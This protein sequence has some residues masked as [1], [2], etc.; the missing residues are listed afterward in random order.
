MP[1]A[2]ATGIAIGQPARFE[3]IA[4][5][6]Q[7]FRG[8]VA[9]VQPVVD[10]ATRSVDIRI[11]LPNP[12][13]DLRPGLFGTVQLEQP[14][15]QPVLT[16]PRSAVLDTGTRQ[17]VLVQGA[18]GR[19]SPR[20]VTLGRRAGD[21]VEVLEGLVDDEA[22]V[23]AANFLIDAESNL[24]SALDGLD[25]HAGHG[26]P[27]SAPAASSRDTQDPAPADGDDHD[28]HELREGDAS[29]ERRESHERH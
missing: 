21:R 24:Q 15:S 10:A 17:V 18:P 4:L 9:F 2:Q 22:V 20:E 5:P 26:E 25:G 6:G 13:G 27:A 28:G 1:V 7:A 29:S 12:D 8:D 3:S 11:A 16:V 14:D 23:V 19:F